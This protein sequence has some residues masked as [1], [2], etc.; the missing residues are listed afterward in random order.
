[1]LEVWKSVGVNKNDI[2]KNV[3][4]CHFFSFLQGKEAQY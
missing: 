3:R 4:W 2:N 1:M